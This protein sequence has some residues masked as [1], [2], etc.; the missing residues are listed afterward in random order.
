MVQMLPPTGALAV[1]LLLAMIVTPF[2]HNAPTVLMLGPIA[3]TLAAKLGL[4][5]DPFLMAESSAPAATS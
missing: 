1:V 5:P 2:L 3:G 4:S